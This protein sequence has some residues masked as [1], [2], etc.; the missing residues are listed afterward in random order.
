MKD[1]LGRISAPAAAVSPT[2]PDQAPPW[3][4]ALEGA[5][6]GLCEA[7]TGSRTTSAPRRSSAHPAEG[8]GGW[9][10]GGR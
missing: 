8:N 6:T 10:G 4:I 5:P 1:E 2:A 3:P 7:H 9:V